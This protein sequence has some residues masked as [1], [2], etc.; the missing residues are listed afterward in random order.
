M[1][2]IVL[3]ISSLAVA[4]SGIGYLFWQQEL[5]YQ[6]STPVPQQFKAVAVGTPIRTDLIPK[7]SAYFL[8]FY[9]PDCPCSR[10][11]AKHVKSLIRSY[12]DSVRMLIVLPTSSDLRAAKKEF[13]DLEMIVDEGG[14][15][16]RSCGVYSTP[17]AVILD[18]N[19]SLYYRGNYNK[20]RYCTSRAS[21]F[22]ELS[23]IALLNHQPSPS[24][25]LMASTAYGCELPTENDENSEFF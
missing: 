11:N 14:N 2:R 9:N 3:A 17:Q 24:F 1:A 25:G 13:G 5:K 7:S 6:L 15:I 23:L 19:G 22:A 20:S 21:N 4:F 16:A 12:H 10:F 18:W 8:H